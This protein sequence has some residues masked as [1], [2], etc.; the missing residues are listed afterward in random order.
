MPARLARFGELEPA[1]AEGLPNEVQLSVA[2]PEPPKKPG[3]LR[4]EVG[5]LENAV[6]ADF[7][8]GLSA[9]AQAEHGVRVFRFALERRAH[10]DRFFVKLACSSA[11]DADSGAYL[12]VRKLKP[13]AP[14][15]AQGDEVLGL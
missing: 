5:R 3:P 2:K 1:L 6:L 11:G 7:L 15:H 8:G 4:G 9:E 14:A 12:L 10:L 13:V